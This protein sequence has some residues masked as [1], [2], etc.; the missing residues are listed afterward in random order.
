MRKR[1]DKRFGLRSPSPMGGGGGEGRGGFFGFFLKKKIHQ[2]EI[3]KEFYFFKDFYLGNIEKEN[4]KIF[5]KKREFI[6]FLKNK[7]ILDEN[8]FWR[9]KKKKK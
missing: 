1:P 3:K 6:K 7:Y 9:K 5:F 4:D 8:F 2:P